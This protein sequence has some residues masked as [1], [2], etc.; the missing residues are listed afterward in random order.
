MRYVCLALVLVLCAFAVANG[1]TPA[2]QSPA[3]DRAPAP[4]TETSKPAQSGFAMPNTSTRP[5]TGDFD[6]MVTRRR[7][8]LL[9]PYWMTAYFVDQAV[10]R[11]LAFGV[12]RCYG[13][14]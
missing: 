10:Q 8:R 7:I 9:V 3:R 6:G 13:A 14:A 12:T 4:A 5:W 2:S 11:A 1:Q